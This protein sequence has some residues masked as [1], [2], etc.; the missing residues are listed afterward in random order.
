MR[1]KAVEKVIE[2]NLDYLVRFACYRL[3]NH[4]D[5]EDL[6]YEAI[7]RLLEKDVSTIKPGG[8]RMYLFRI[9]YNMCLD[10]SRAKTL[11]TIPVENLEIPDSQEADS[12]TKDIDRINSTLAGLRERESEIIRMN[13][14]DGLSFADIGNILSIPTS[15]AK[16]RYKAGMEKLRKQLSNDKLS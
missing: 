9:V 13:V 16:S 14:I 11:E 4:S 12:A 1:R 2:D 3:G 7:L 15:T 6:V 8:V 10:K 5:A